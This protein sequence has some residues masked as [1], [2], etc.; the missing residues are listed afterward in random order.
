MASHNTNMC[1]LM[2]CIYV[3]EA[4]RGLQATFFKCNLCNRVH[5]VRTDYHDGSQ[6]SCNFSAGSGTLAISNC[7]SQLE[8]YLASLSVPIM[9]RKTFQRY[10]NESVLCGKLWL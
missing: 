6:A 3:R 1:N 9:T 7:Y 2:N 4:R 10:E 8:E 5:Q